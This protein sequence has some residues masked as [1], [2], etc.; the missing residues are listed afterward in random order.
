MHL[1][2]KQRGVKLHDRFNLA[3]HNAPNALKFVLMATS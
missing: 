2:F 1:N 3:Y